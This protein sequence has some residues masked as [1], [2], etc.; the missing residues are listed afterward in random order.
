MIPALFAEKFKKENG[1]VVNDLVARYKTLSP[2][3]LIYALTAMKNRPDRSQLLKDFTKSFSIIAGVQDQ[4]V[5]MEVVSLTCK[6]SVE[7]Q[8]VFL[9]EVAHMGMIEFS[10]KCTDYILRSM[11]SSTG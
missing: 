6:L 11:D 10:A 7:T 9:R 5:T 3:G 8:A 1:D 4:V 2:D